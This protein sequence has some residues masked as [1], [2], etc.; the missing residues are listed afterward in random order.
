[1]IYVVAE[2][3]LPG[4]PVK[5]GYTEGPPDADTVMARLNTLQTAN[6]RRLVVIAMKSGDQQDENIVHLRNGA[7]RL[8]GEWFARSPD[9]VAFI[10]ANACAPIPSTVGAAR[11]RR[12]Q[13][14]PLHLKRN[15]QRAACGEATN[16]WR[17]VTSDRREM[18]FD[19]DI[20][21]E[22]CPQC[23]NAAIHAVL[24]RQSSAAHFNPALEPKGASTAAEPET[25]EIA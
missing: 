1:M 17:Y 22:R 5:I 19:D 25:K 14:G 13:S 4:G 18:L 12:V 20:E 7:H 9:V 15:D 23:W 16:Q 24:P 6:W 2:E 8:I 10:D 11:A 21:L 3:D